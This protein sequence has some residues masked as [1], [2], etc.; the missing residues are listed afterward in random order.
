MDPGTRAPAGLLTDAPSGI[1]GALREVVGP[2]DRVFNPQRW[3]SW[4][5]YAFPEALVAVDS[6]IELYPATLWQD[7]ESA[8]AGREGWQALFGSWGPTTVITSATDGRLR[9]AL[10]ADGWRSVYSDR[11]GAV[12]VRP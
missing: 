10:V 11:D 8:V 5:E 12:L 6:R 9:D 3:G 1:T 7:Y 4:L 2:S